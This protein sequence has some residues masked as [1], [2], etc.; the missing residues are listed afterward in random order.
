MTESARPLVVR[1]G[2]LGDMVLLTVA[3]RRLHQR[4]GVPV[5]ILGS[6][7]WTRPLLAGQPGVGEIYL[8]H[9][10]RRPFWLGPDQW[11]LVRQLQRRGAGPTWLFDADNDKTRWLLQRAGWLARHFLTP[12]QMPQ[13]PGE[14]FCDRWRRF[15]QLVPAPTAGAEADA[16]ESRNATDAAPALQVTAQGRADLA[17]LL[18][19]LGLAG[20]PLILVQA[21]NKRTMRLGRRQ[22][23]SNT[24]YWP[25]E[26]WAAVLRTLR[27]LHP[28]HALLLLGIA[29]EA[30][31]NAEILALAGIENAHN[32][33]G[34]IPVPH[35]MALAERAFGML[36]VDTGPAHL[37]AAVGCPVLALYASPVAERIYAVRGPG[38]PTR[39]LTGGS[40]AAPSLLGLTPAQ[41]VDAW[42]GLVEEVQAGEAATTRTKSSTRRS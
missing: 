23:I 8:L 39:C 31:M 4:F 16:A 10:R 35:L 32:L 7:A 29:R 6:G 9:S 27:A 2:A 21:G 13:V 18:A 12:E 3:I 33:A 14:P 28:Q 19:R 40:D 37:C 22:R 20:R 17:A 30:Q 5:D 15:A 38:V 34:A 26:R 36:S 24:K 42:G 1:F 25:E 11:R 41:V